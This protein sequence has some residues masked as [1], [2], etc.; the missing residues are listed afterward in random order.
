MVSLLGG[1]FLKNPL[2]FVYGYFAAAAMAGLAVALVE[3]KDV[4]V[5][6]SPT[7]NGYRTGVF[8]CVEG[9]RGHLVGGYILSRMVKRVT[10]R[11]SL[12]VRKVV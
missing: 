1:Q 7:Y 5:H 9:E 8:A 3:V 11:G 4:T 12:E 2:I 6:I 10:S